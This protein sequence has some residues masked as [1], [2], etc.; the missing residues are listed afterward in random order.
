MGYRQVI[1]EYLEG[2]FSAK[3]PLKIPQF[4][5]FFFERPVLLSRAGILWEGQ[6]EVPETIAI[7]ILKYLIYGGK[8]GGVYHPDW[9]GFRDIKD[10]SP[11]QGAFRNNVE[12]RIE[13]YFA[14]NTHG[15]MKACEGLK[16][17]RLKMEG[18]DLSY[19]FLA[20]PQVGLRLLYNDTEDIFPPQAKLLFSKD[21]ERFLDVECIAGLGWIF[22]DLLLSS[23]GYESTFTG[24]PNATPF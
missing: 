11:F 4:R 24:R 17:K 10:S 9:V 19:E 7:V 6:G 3:A 12:L 2:I 21:I 20:L 5:L 23:S 13:R 1:E 22:A 14:Q 8:R 15:L 18:Y 16:G